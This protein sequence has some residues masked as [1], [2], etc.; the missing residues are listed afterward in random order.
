MGR[1]EL[2]ARTSHGHVRSDDGLPCALLRRGC[3][4]QHRPFEMRGVRYFREFTV[5]PTLSLSP[6]YPFSHHA[7]S[8][9]QAG[10]ATTGPVV[11]PRTSS[12]R[13]RCAGYTLPGT[14]SNY[15][16]ATA[17]AEP[18]STRYVLYCTVHLNSISHTTLETDIDKLLQCSTSERC[19]AGQCK[20]F[21]DAQWVDL[22]SNPYHCGACGVV[23]S[24]LSIPVTHWEMCF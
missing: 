9:A 19:L 5:F 6:E 15:L 22:K 8:S 14:A 21:C 7:D 1:C 17:T 20:G 16:K 10:T 4:P 2:S 24:L 13:S 3:G 11:A 18:A 23:V 12:P